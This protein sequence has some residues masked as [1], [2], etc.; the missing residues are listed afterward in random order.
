M[1]EIV[2]MKAVRLDVEAMKVVHLGRRG[3]AVVTTPTSLSPREPRMNVH[4]N[5]RLTPQG[6]ALLVRRIGAEGWRVR[7]AAAAA[8]ISQRSAFRWLARHR[9]GGKLAL[10]DKSSAP[11]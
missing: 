7:D 4:K 2:N 11:A 10:Q 8:G 9:A 5:A 1:S 3:E 6:R